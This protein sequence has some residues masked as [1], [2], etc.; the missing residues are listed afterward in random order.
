MNKK[1]NQKLLNIVKQNY[2]EIAD[3][4]SNTRNYVWPELKNIIA[5]RFPK[6]P[7]GK[8]SK[9]Y[10]ILDLGC[11]NGRLFELF[12]N[13]KKISYI[14]IDQSD[15]LI[16]IARIKYPRANFLQQNILEY[17]NS[18]EKFNLILLI[19]VLQHIPSYSLRL[20][21]LKKIKKNLQPKGEIII[22]NWDLHKNKKYKK[23]IYK[24]AILKLLGINK[25][26]FND[27]L[28]T[29]FNSSSQRYYHAFT[30]KELYK[31]LNQVGFKIKKLYSDNHNIYAICEN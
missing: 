16:N 10:R 22:S 7:C 15:N 20:N 21:F 24:Y 11:G 6:P 25:M 19:A 17:E 1:T 12:K 4:F 30:K 26:D 14:G 23:L 9:T 5:R 2:E 31:L 28:F 27:I 29:G 3:N 8:V 13:N 18:N